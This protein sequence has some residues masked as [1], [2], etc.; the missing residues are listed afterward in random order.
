LSLF[1]KFPHRNPVHASPLP[2][3]LHPSRH[4]VSSHTPLLFPTNELSLV[5]CCYNFRPAI[6]AIIRELQYYKDK[7]SVPCVSKWWTYIYT[8]ARAHAH[9]HKQH[10]TTVSSLTERNSGTMQNLPFGVN[11][12]IELRATSNNTGTLLSSSCCIFWRSVAVL[13]PNGN[14]LDCATTAFNDRTDV[15]HY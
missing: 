10:Y 5:F 1:L 2:Y 12:V 6:V 3:A 8:R 15:Q 13:N 14:F 11:I 4:T 7:T 9:T